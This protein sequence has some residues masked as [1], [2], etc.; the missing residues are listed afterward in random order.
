MKASPFRVALPVLL[1]LA[2]A[3][4]GGGSQPAPVQDPPLAPERLR[5]EV[6]APGLYQLTYEDLVAAGYSHGSYQPGLFSLST[7][8]HPVA[9]QVHCADGLH[10][11]P[12][13]TVSFYGQG[14]DTPYSGTAVYW[15][16]QGG[17]RAIMSSR[18][19]AASGSPLPL[20]VHQETL[21]LEQNLTASG[22]IPGSPAQDYWFWAKLTAPQTGSYPFQLAGLAEQAGAS[23]LTVSLQGGTS[24]GPNPDHHAQV[25]LNGTLV[26]DLTWFGM[27][28]LTQTFPLP[29]GVLQAGGNTVSVVLPGDTGAAA[30]VVFLNYV[31]VTHWGP[32][33]ALGDVAAIPVTGGTY[34]PIQVQG[35][36]SA[37]VELLDITD[38]SNPALL[39]SPTIVSAG[40]AYQATFQDPSAVTRTY[41]VLTQDQVQKPASFVPWIAGALR[42]PSAGADYLLITP[43]AFLAAAEPLC[44][45]RRNQGLRVAAVAV[46]DVYNEFA[47]GQPDPQALKDF[48]AYAYASWPRPAPTYVLFLGDATFDYRNRLGTGKLSQVPCH[49]TW[50]SELG[51]TPD[52]NWFV[53]LDGQDE[54]PS[55]MLGRLPSASAT[56]AAVLVQKILGYESTTAAP[57]QQA[58]FVA[59]NNDASFPTLCDGLAGQLPA[60]IT[61]D[62]VYLS[63]YTDFTKCSQDIISAFN[64]GMLVATY[65][66]HGDPTVWTGEMVFDASKL[67]SLTNDGS[68]LS[69]IVS[70]DCLNGWFALSSGYCLSESVVAAPSRGAIASYAS[71]GLGLEWEQQLVATRLFGL[72]FAGGKP[73]LGAVCTGAKVQAY[74]AGASKEVLE[75]M[76]LI[77]DPAMRLRGLP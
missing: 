36:T 66:G 7:Q 19:V 10:F 9:L 65:A 60:A 32:N 14:L 55:M 54:L 30:D 52:D 74:K 35:F 69:F 47:Y 67:P 12:G 40:S 56:Q 50:T 8:G 59:D 45:L 26:G 33:Q 58:L 71:S 24:G 17:S 44:Q 37:A 18:R 51:L 75:T 41:Y 11:G 34:L 57:P 20:T 2:W 46:E 49:L 61:A 48:L 23:C 73:T 64:A 31:E 77:G 1:L 25:S 28:P 6:S 5:M 43:R 72:L 39:T 22:V 38:P 63:S 4:C 29:P 70:L 76:T 15:L 21:H 16:G 53:A 3:G 42:T 27:I 13:D 62:K 68:K